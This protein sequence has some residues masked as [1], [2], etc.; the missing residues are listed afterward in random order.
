MRKRGK[1]NTLGRSPKNRR[2]DTSTEAA[3]VVM[4]YENILDPT[5]AT[6]SS[7]LSPMVIDRQEALLQKI[8]IM[9]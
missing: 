7:H 5:K 3:T 9:C 4:K 6:E 2:L 1:S 8:K